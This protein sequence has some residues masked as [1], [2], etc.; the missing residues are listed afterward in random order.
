MWGFFKWSLAH[1]KILYRSPINFVFVINSFTRYV[2]RKNFSAPNSIQ[3]ISV[4]AA[5]VTSQLT[6]N[7]NSVSPLLNR[8]IFK[9]SLVQKTERSGTS[10]CKSGPHWA[11]TKPG[12]AAAQIKLVGLTEADQVLEHGVLAQVSVLQLPD[13]VSLPGLR[14]PAGSPRRQD[15]AARVWPSGWICR[16]SPGGDSGHD[17][18]QP[19]PLH[20]ESTPT[21]APSPA[22]CYRRLWVED[23]APR[24]AAMSESPHSWCC[25]CLF[26]EVCLFVVLLSSPLIRHSDGGGAEAGGSCCQLPG[27]SANL[28]PLARF[29]IWLKEEKNKRTPRDTWKRH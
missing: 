4:L 27:V 1:W 24:T 12:P 21:D 18:P 15:R 9:W 28:R 16:D 26:S 5:V 20:A 29:L 7:D 2:T 10:V 22:W 25:C 6:P 23:L 3:K 11:S 8:L 19:R 13:D 17:A 14:R